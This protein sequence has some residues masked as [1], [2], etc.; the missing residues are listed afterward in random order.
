M[1]RLVYILAVLAVLAPVLT[2]C[3]EEKHYYVKNIGS[4]DTVPTMRTTD[5]NTYISDSG[6]TKYYIQTPVWEMYNEANPPYWRFPQ[7]VHLEQYD[8]RQHVESTLRCDS[9]RY[10]MQERLWRLDGRVVGVNVNHDSILTNQLFWDQSQRK[11]Y[12]D[13]FIHIVRSDRIIEGYGFESNERMTEFVIKKPT[14]IFPVDNKRMGQGA[15]SA[16][17]PE[18][19]F[20]EDERR[21][22]A[23]RRASERSEMLH[24]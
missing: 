14:G 20:N 13:S 9:A 11:L 15:P 23:P 22:P 7:E 3:D 24:F 19:D 16:T 17:T 1:R 2:G 21:A 12:S 10:L 4:G 5:V 6:Y 8:S 18:D